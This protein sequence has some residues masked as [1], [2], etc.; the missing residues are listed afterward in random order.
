MNSKLHAYTF[1][2]FILNIILLSVC[3]T[4]KLLNLYD[5]LWRKLYTIDQLSFSSSPCDYFKWFDFLV[6][7]CYISRLYYL[8]GVVCG[9]FCCFYF[10][11]YFIETGTNLTITGCLRKFMQNILV[12][13]DIPSSL[14][15]RCQLLHHNNDILK[16][17]F[18]VV[19]NTWHS[20]FPS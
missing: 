4:C 14:G 7:S 12:S 3:D 20:E 13:Y 17:R 5:H 9:C 16:R 10:I 6:I 15:C 19:T 18:A 8:P 11:E 2:L 1:R